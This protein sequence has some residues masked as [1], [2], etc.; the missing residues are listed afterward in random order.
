M[1][2]YVTLLANFAEINEQNII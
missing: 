1:N 2:N